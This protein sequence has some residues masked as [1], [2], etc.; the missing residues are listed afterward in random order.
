M[1]QVK[2]W[3]TWLWIS[4]KFGSLL[5]QY[6]HVHCSSTDVLALLML[7]VVFNFWCNNLLDW[8]FLPY[9]VPAPVYGI[10]YCIYV[11]FLTKFGSIKVLLKTT[12][13]STKTIILLFPWVHV[14][15]AGAVNFQ[16]TL[17]L[18]VQF[19]SGNKTRMGSVSLLCHCTSAPCAYAALNCF[20]CRHVRMQSQDT[21][22]WLQGTCS[23]HIHV[24][25]H[26]VGIYIYT[27]I[28]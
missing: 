15:P 24:H 21:H 3:S 17:T 22:D 8:I 6:I 20:S 23:R 7:V 11:A 16:T 2:C 4:W 10:L 26:S 13:T 28:G 19:E 14:L 9:L 18:G 12:K 27:Y 25:V 5:F 1:Y